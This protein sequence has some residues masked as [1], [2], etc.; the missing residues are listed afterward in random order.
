[1]TTSTVEQIKERLNIVDVISSYVKL[2]KA[3]SNL[4]AKC[5]FHNEKSP[6]FMVSPTRNSYH[7]FGCNRGGDIF[8]FTE[9]IEGIDFYSALKLL[10]D[11]A[12]VEIKNINPEEKSEQNHLYDILEESTK[13]FENNLYKNPEVLEYL[14]KRGLKD[15]TIKE[16][17]IGYIPNE[18]RLLL[19]YL[20]GKNFK[21]PQIEKVGLIIKSE[22]GYYDRFRGRIMFPLN[23]SQGRTVG[24]SGRI[25]NESEENKGAKYVNSPE[26]VLYNK[27]K[28]LYGYD[29]AKRY[30]MNADSCILVEGQIDLI[31][32]HQSGTRNTVAVSGTALTEE[33]ISLIKRFSDNLLLAFDADDAGFSASE[34][35]VKLALASSLDV[36][37]VKIKGGK[38]PAE[39]ILENKEEWQGSLKEAKHIVDFYLEML[40]EKDY[41]ERMLKKEVV[42]KILPYV[43]L[44]NNKIDQSHFIRKIANKLSVEEELIKGEV[45]KIASPATKEDLRNQK[46][47]AGDTPSKK[48]KDIMKDKIT[49]IILWQESEKIPAVNIEEI[50]LKYKKISERDFDTEIKDITEQ[51]KQNLI[52]Q[53]EFYYLND[54]NLKSEIDELLMNLEKELLEEQ[55]A[56]LMYNLK[57]AENMNDLN[58]A[59][60]ILKECHDLSKKI[61]EIK[62]SRFKL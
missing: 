29:K 12:G 62:N 27:S 46:T 23:N 52:L 57:K 28:I 51:E 42:K 26:T 49:G 59:T 20:Q 3:G 43:S 35:S 7:C 9:D 22:K 10:A 39:M 16:F 30:I 18:W 25:F 55:L 53:A 17:R 34:R 6:S 4:K 47:E 14:R 36:K 44:I 32:A 61:N 37:I 54:K 41:E 56:K 50:K 33:H 58:L 24:F 1:M 11:R 40:M 19:H 48:M 31:M 21:E 38:D 2:E 8:T 15:E 45:D 5:P 13:F 60:V